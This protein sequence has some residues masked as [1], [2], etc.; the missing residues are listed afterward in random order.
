MSTFG[1]EAHKS[2]AA[3]VAPAV[4][5]T[6]AP[7]A[8]PSARDVAERLCDLFLCFPCAVWEGVQWRVLVR[9]YEERYS[10]RLDVAALGHSTPVAAATVLL[11]NVLGSVDSDDEA[12]PLLRID[13]AVALIPKPGR[14]GCWPSLYHA[15]HEIARRHGEKGLLLSRLK[16]LLL[17]YWH[18]GFDESGHGFMSSDGSTSK[19]RK[20]KHLV[21]DVRRW[22]N[23]RL[24]WREA[25]GLRPTPVDEALAPCLELSPSDSH[26]DLVLR[27]TPRR[28]PALEAVHGAPGRAGGC[29]GAALDDPFDDPFEPPP[30]AGPWRAR[31]GSAR[32]GACPSTAG[33][34]TSA[35][36]EFGAASASASASCCATPR[37]ASGAATPAQAAAALLPHEGIALLPLWWSLAPSAPQF[38]VIPQGIVQSIRSQFEPPGWRG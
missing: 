6:S 7:S 32:Q 3:L 23:E 16:P 30:E 5:A 35:G 28:L 11:W 26:N 14:L 13:D 4:P 8:Q 18:A 2:L 21:Q 34:S 20:M 9:K 31:R 36:S 22:R 33:L 24:A 15:L 19:S 29:A 38:S 37:L 17:R 10:T 12:N 27:C 25:R 1:A